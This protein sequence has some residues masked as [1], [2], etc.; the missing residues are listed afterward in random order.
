VESYIRESLERRKHARR[1]EN[2]LLK[3]E[4]E[5]DEGK[6]RSAIFIDALALRMHSVKIFSGTSRAPC[7]QLLLWHPTE[8]QVLLSEQ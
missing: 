2:R 8:H 5:S 7:G 6:E 4:L 1:G 3:R